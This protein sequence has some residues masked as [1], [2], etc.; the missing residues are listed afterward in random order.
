MKDSPTGASH[1]RTTTTG[2]LLAIILVAAISGL[3]HARVA[4]TASESQRNPLTVIAATYNAQQSYQR[5]VSYLGLVVAGKKANLG[6]EMAGQIALLPMR[7]GDSVSTG[8]IIATLDTR[9][10]QARRTATLAELQQAR[11]ELELAELKAKRQRNL[12]KT[13]AVS[14]EAYDETRLR[15]KSL[16]ARVAAVEAQLAS[17]DIDLD[18]SRLLAPYDGIIADRY[19]YQGA[20]V[21]PGT[22]VVRLVETTA[23]EAHIGVAAKRAADLDPGQ[24]YTLVLNSERITAELLSVRPDVDPH[25]RTTTAVFGLPA[26]VNPLD[27]EPVT[28]TLEEDIELAGAW[29]PLGAL[30]EGERGVWN[31]LRLV[32]EG[33]GFRTVREAVEVIDLQADKAYVRGTLSDGDAVIASGLNR[34]TPGSLVTLQQGQ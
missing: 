5:P 34:I 33:N 15:A 12:S 3:L 21:A 9:A 18:K 16:S 6:F 24:S 4:I 1:V 14:E 19:V 17:I 7:Q 27:G 23:Q 28:L 11:S 31:T 30:L 10:L 26:N 29:L 25:T 2:I 8:D 13:G 32:P 22:P 20:V